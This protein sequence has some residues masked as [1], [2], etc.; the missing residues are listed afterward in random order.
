M[1][2][3]G[4]LSRQAESYGYIPQRRLGLS[5]FQ[6]QIGSNEANKALE[7]ELGWSAT[8]SEQEQEGE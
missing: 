3:V 1:S 6:Q 5:W 8:A 7:I 2:I 4:G